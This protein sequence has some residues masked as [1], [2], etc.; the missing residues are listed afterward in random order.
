MV[1]QRRG[2][3][4]DDDD[5]AERDAKKVMDEQEINKEKEGRKGCELQWLIIHPSMDRT[6][7]AKLLV[8]HG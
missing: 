3:N 1:E 7:G 4:D 8:I 6:R 2:E 5:D